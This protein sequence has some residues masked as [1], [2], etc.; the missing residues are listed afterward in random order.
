MMERLQRMRSLKS[1][2]G[3]KTFVRVFGPEIKAMAKVEAL[4]SVLNV[5]LAHLT[6]PRAPSS[7]T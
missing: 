3:Y 4:S 5:L 6:A 2:P 1:Y 7:G